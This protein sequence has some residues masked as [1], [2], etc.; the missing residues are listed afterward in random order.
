[1]RVAC[2]QMCSGDDVTANITA[3]DQ[4]LKQASDQGVKLI[5]LPENFAFM[6]PYPPVRRPLTEVLSSSAILPFLAEAATRYTLHIVGGSLL[7]PAGGGKN[8][9]ACPVF[10]PDGTC[11]ACYKKLHLFD[12]DLPGESHRES[13][14]IAPGTHPVWLDLAGWRLGLSICYDLRFPELYRHY[15]H[16]GC[17]LI[18]VPSAFTVSTGKAHWEILLRA[19][20]IENQSYVLA[21]AQGGNHPGGRQTWGHSMIV[22]PWGE[23]VARA[24]ENGQEK[25]M[26]VI[27]E[28]DHERVKQVRQQIPA[29]EHRR[30][31]L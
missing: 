7:L 20:A 30:P 4:L 10:A 12:V 14:S 27:A 18:T 5:V 26:L 9:N 2:V 6:A 22:D 16:A 15:A 8:Q 25:P 1:M 17:Q 21:A 13:T 28:V 24:E 23:I 11:L 19:R 31:E 29:L 3:V